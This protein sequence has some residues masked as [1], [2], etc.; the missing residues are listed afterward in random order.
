MAH[1]NREL[2]SYKEGWHCQ[3]APPSTRINLARQAARILASQGDWETSSSLLEEAIKLLPVVSPR[4]LKHTDKQYMLAEFSGLASMAA[5]VSLEA[6]RS[7]YDTL[8]LLE[9][10]RGVIANLL[11]D[12]RGDTSTLEQR[13]PDLANQFK[14]LRDALDS[15]V[16]RTTSPILTNGTSSWVSQTKLRYELDRKFGEL[17]ATIR[18][19]PGFDNFLLPP[20]ETEVKDAA[21]LGPIVIVNLSP[22]RCDAFLVERDRI[23]VLGLPDLKLGDVRKEAQNLRSSS[24]IAVTPTLEWLWNVVCG[25]SLD[26]LGFGSPVSDNN[27]PRV[28]W[29]PTGLLSQFPLHAA[30]YHERGSTKTVLDRAMSSYAPSV[31]ALIHGRKHHVHSSVATEPD[32]ALLV[33]M[34]QTPDL[35]TSQVLPFVEKEV[36]VLKELYASL[37][38][39][40]V[41][42][43][44]RKD[45]VLKS[46]QGCK[47]FHFAGHGS[48]HLTEPSQSYLLL[49]DWKTNPLTVGDIRDR[50]FQENPPFLG[51]LSACLTGVNEAEELADEGIHL[52]SAFQ[53]AGFRHVIGTLWEVSDK[54]CADVARVFY[55]TMR[56]EGLTDLAVCRGLHRAM[57]AV[58]DGHIEEEAAEARNATVVKM[59]H[60]TNLYWV[61]YIHLGV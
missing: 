29:I 25:P 45:A 38:L 1:L 41:T 13:H 11:M 56:D 20:T 3:N 23:R 54:H 35:P 50:K 24:L 14:S 60:L 34:K 18:A 57:R 51:Y 30:G 42:P 48:S 9:L 17:I 58:R 32:H 27:W 26:A 19:Q 31:K 2:C 47:I 40:C 43:A 52:V 37:Q 55:E 61:P 36:K 59:E 7:A 10:G 21:C 28:W 16:D 33:A 49:E 12:M 4:S 15:P 53:L 44:L 39:K 46:L 8:R 5:A 22:Y 6:G